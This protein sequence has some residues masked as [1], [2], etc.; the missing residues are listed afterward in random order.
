MAKMESSPGNENALE[1]CRE[2]VSSFGARWQ[3][4]LTIHE[5]KSQSRTQT[6]QDE[7]RE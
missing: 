6:G 7:R 1:S 3:A 5:R 2:M 4:D